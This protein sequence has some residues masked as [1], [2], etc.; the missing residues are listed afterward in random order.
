MNIG[1]P[2]RAKAFTSS[3]L[4]TVKVKLKAG[5]FC[6]GRGGKLLADSLD[7]VPE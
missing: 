3:T 7:V 4:I 6:V 1:P 2:G 5:G